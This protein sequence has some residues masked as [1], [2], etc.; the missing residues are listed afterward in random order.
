MYVFWVIRETR[1]HYQSKFSLVIL[2]GIPV[3][4]YKEVNQPKLRMADWLKPPIGSQLGT[5]Y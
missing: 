5:G 4:D 2:A 3:K 1:S